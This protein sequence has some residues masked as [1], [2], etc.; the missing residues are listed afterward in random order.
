MNY[1]YV[2]RPSVAPQQLPQFD[3]ELP[4]TRLLP[5]EFPDYNAIDAIDAQNVL[6]LSLH[7]K[8][9]T[10]REDGV[11]NLV[12]WA[13]YSDWR[14]TR[15][16]GQATFADLYS[17][18]DLQPFSWLLL[19]SETRYNLNDRN[20]TE[21]NHAATFT[22]NTT[23]NLTVGHRYLRDNPALGT[24]YGNNIIFSSIYF[25]FNEN[26]GV[27][28]SH[29]FEARDGVMEEQYYTLYH[30]LRSWTGALTFRIRDNRVGAT[31]YTLALTMSLKAFPRFGMG[32]D[33][34]KPEL[35]L[36]Y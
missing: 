1:V 6:R 26:W 18:L 20:W 29:H 4:T 9:Q 25:R 31:D 19:N 13:L 27:R 14:I 36:H 24:N 23:W 15:H 22:P 16:H 3:T 17:D 28:L 12:N 7:N 5:I 35:L 2:P 32:D 21:A 30:D 10:K 8:L 11:E 33:A 34:A